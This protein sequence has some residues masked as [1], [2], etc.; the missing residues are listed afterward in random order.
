[1]QE[2]GQHPRNVPGIVV[3][4]M[5]RAFKRQAEPLQCLVQPNFVRQPVH[6]RKQIF[7]VEM[8]RAE[9]IANATRLTLALELPPVVIAVAGPAALPGAVLGF[10]QRARFP[11][12]NPVGNL[13]GREG[14]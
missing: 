12:A 1:M 3:A 14:R 7:D 8:R 11:K 6:Q 10:K 9:R 13:R 5:M 2:M 4:A